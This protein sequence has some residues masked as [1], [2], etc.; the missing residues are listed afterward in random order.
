M[1]LADH[2]RIS[3]AT[4]DRVRAAAD[5]LDYVPNSMGRSLRSQ[6]IGAIALVV[7][8]ASRQVFM[9][10]Y[11]MEVLEGISEVANREGLSLVLS[12]A[13]VE[14][15]EDAY[16]RLLQGRR[17][18]GVIVA[19]AALGDRN[20][21]RLVSSGYPV[22]FLGRYPHD[23]A[24]PTVTVDDRGGAEKATSHLAQ[25]HR[26]T[27]IAHIAG[28][29][30]HLAFLDRHE[31]YRASLARAGMPYIEALVV[32]GDASEG[33]GYEACDALLRA[34]RPFDG[35]FVSNDEMALGALRRLRVEGLTVPQDVAIVGFDDVALASVVEPALT[36]VRQPMRETARLAAERLVTSLDSRS[37]EPRHLE[38]ATELIV[39]QSC[40][41][42]EEESMA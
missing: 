14:N 26:L 10:P 25:V 22:V 38:L 30:D 12:T 19:G 41:C 33:S 4:K 39:R 42:R 21:N 40:G 3:D 29:L 36:T 16:R 34:G 37:P 17:A 15:G 2:S 18:D 28:P 8:L 35:I 27:A 11:F 32:E 20:I 7:P 24:V 31:G 1:A 13:H 23:A 9:H 5:K 6:R